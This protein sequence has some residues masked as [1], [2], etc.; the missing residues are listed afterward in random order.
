MGGQ[1]CIA[2]DKN[3]ALKALKTTLLQSTY[4]SYIY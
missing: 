4:Q 2:N 1:T 3:Q